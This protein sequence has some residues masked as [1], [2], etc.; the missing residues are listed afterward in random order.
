VYRAARRPVL[1]VLMHSVWLRSGIVL[2]LLAKSTPNVFSVEGH[3][4]KLFNAL[5]RRN[6]AQEGEA[7][8]AARTALLLRLDALS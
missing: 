4:E 8:R 2:N 6:A 3:R 1:L 7:T 5:K